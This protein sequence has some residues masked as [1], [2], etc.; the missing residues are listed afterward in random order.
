V[1]HRQVGINA[2]GLTNP[3]GHVIG[4]D[5]GAT[6]VRAAVM[7]LGTHEGRPSVSVHGLGEVALPQGAVLNGVV[8]D[9]VAVTNALKQLWLVN[10]FE[11]RNVIL[12]VSNQ[13]IVVRDLQVP[14][15]PP[16]QLEKA[17]PFQAREVIPLQLDQVLLDFTPLGP[18]D[19][20]TDLVP[21]LLIATPRQP[22]VAAVQ[23]VERAGL[24]VARVD[25]SSFAALRAIADENLAVE[26]V[27]DIGAHVTN[28]VIHAQGVPKVV[29]TLTRG[30]QELTERIVDRVGI[31]QPEA[32]LAKRQLGLGD[33]D[34]RIGEA[35][36]E[37]VRP[38]LTEIR[39]SV[40]YF[41]SSFAG[42]ELE[43]LSLTGGGAALP[44]LARELETQL[45][46]ATRVV[47]PL[48]HVR[49]RWANKGTQEAET[50]R[51]ATAVSVG[52]AM[53]AAA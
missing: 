11:C 10:K 51:W 35:I 42:L 39:S 1:K 53:G 32:E 3:D 8:C 4:L 2:V 26:A 33:G 37:G 16:E 21:G 18:P 41:T 44:G 20:V 14:N 45:S 31:T 9:P 6:S 43:R 17:L 24:H 50:Q 7:S 27:I 19:R 40:H 47:D 29:R 46:V 34:R 15:L 25:L 13:Q 52:L 12:G 23:A 5:I 38:L 28:I 49:N 22:V 36:L 48:Q 30:S